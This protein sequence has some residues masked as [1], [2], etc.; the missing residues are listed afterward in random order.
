VGNPVSYE[1]DEERIAGDHRRREQQIARA[2]QI[3]YELAGE[4]VT[5]GIVRAILELVEA[6][7]RDDLPPPARHPQSA[8]GARQVLQKK[9]ARPDR[10]EQLTLC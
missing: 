8:P 7:E 5:R 2:E 10:G 4:R 3:A 1:S 9:P 6:D